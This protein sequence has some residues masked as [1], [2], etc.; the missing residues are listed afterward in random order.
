MTVGENVYSSSNW[1]TFHDFLLAYPLTL[2]GEHW[3][4]EQSQLPEG[5]LHQ[6]ATWFKEGLSLARDNVDRRGRIK[7]AP[8]SGSLLGYLDFSYSLYLVEHNC[9]IPDRV[10]ERLRDPKEFL[11]A[12]YELWVAAWFIK[13][14]FRVSH[15]DETDL[16]KKH[17]EF[18]AT[19]PATG[20]SFS[21][22]AKRRQP[23]ER[24]ELVGRNLGRATFFL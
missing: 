12:F 19:Y 15:E 4:D 13:G 8:V 3:F 5:E 18:T 16:S 10:Q 22:E 20:T 2:F 1:K 11:G 23:G 21:V 9:G 7:S 14:G 6:A 24:P 17:C